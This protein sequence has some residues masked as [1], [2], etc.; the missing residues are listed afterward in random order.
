MTTFFDFKNRYYDKFEVSSTPIDKLINNYEKKIT[1]NSKTYLPTIS[2]RDNE[3]LLDFFSY[4]LI[5]L[6]A[7][8]IIFNH[9]KT[10]AYS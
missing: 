8:I 10:K 9:K 5:Q 3:I 2:F 4:K 7:G 6:S 1:V